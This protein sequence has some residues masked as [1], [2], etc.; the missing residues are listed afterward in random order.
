MKKFLIVMLTIAC[1]AGFAF[2]EAL[3]IGEKPVKL[4]LDGKNGGRMD[5]APWC[6]C[7]LENT[8][9][10][11]F[12]VDPDESDMNVVAEDALDVLDISKDK[13]KTAAVINYKG[14]KS[15]GF[16]VTMILKNK[17]KKYPDTLYL[18]DKKH[19]FVN[20]WGLTDNS[21]CTLVFD[22]TGVLVYRFDGPMDEEEIAK[23]LQTIKDNL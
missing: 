23:Y 2:A 3:V 20:T 12:Y 22:K 1:L 7:E 16:I 15:P 19:V 4:E 11:M 21:Y 14:T 17:Q 13:L 10:V 8:A 18:T 5:K 9:W 6:S